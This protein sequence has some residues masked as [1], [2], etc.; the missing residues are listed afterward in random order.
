MKQN[1]AVQHG[2]YDSPPG[3]KSGGTA[4]YNTVQVQGALRLRG[5]WWVW[6]V[7]FFFAW[8]VLFVRPVVTVCGERGG[9]KRGVENNGACI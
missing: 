8:F 7:A 4:R 2:R 3:P 1:S 5:G 6:P 9:V